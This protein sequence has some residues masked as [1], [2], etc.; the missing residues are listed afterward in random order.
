MTPRPHSETPSGDFGIAGEAI[1]AE[2]QRR[3]ERMSWHN[4]MLLLATTLITTIGLTVSVGSLLTGRELMPW[5]WSGSEIILLAGLSLVVALFGWHLTCERRRIVRLQH[6][7]DSARE[8]AVR[9]TTRHYNRL[10]AVFGVSQAMASESDL[11]AVFDSITQS[12]FG[13]FDCDRVSLMLKDRKTTELEVRAA[14]G[15]E[16]PSDLVGTRQAI[17]QGIAGWVAEHKEPVILG[18]VVDP[19][20]FRGFEPSKSGLT[21]ALVVPIVVRDELVGVISLSSRVAGNSYTEADLR[22][23]QVFAWNAGFCIRHAEQAEWMRQTIWRLEGSLQKHEREAE[24]TL[25]MT[26]S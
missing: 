18:E 9:S 11:Q 2:R 25:R 7:L 23:L 20:K 3:L 5:A 17:G 12:C 26:G 15:L 8:D 14:V 10:M 21:A 24:T 13:F 1:P 22:A 19:T 4:W 6:E 16:G